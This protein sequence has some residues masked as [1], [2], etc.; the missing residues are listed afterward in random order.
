MKK[1]ARYF[2]FLI[3]PYISS[4]AMAAECRDLNGSWR[5]QLGELSVGLN[6]NVSGSSSVE[7]AGGS[8][9]GIVG[10]MGSTCQIK[11]GIPNLWIWHQVSNDR[12]T[13]WFIRVIVDGHLSNPNELTI[14]TFKYLNRSGNSEAGSGVLYK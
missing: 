5:G 14:K 11:D 12:G 4:T 8:E 9:G 7:L 13:D 6:I 10:G 1:I 2:L 3:A